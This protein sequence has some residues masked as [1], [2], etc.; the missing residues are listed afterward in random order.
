MENKGIEKGIVY[1]IDDIIEYVPDS[2]V[3]KTILKKLTGIIALASY[4]SGKELISKVY[5]FD[6][7]VMLLEGRAAIT[8]NKTV[9]TIVAF[10]SIIIPAHQNYVISAVD[11]FKLLTVTIKSGYESS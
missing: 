7:F 3:S 10:Q 11:R 4:D 8:L 1:N 9:N 5:P 2:I 6:T